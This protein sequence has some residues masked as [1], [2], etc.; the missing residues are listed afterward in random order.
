MGKTVDILAAVQ[1]VSAVGQA[2]SLVFSFRHKQ[3]GRFA[4]SITNC[5][6]TCTSSKQVFRNDIIFIN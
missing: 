6:M 3:Q 2:G 5:E 4:S 1:Q